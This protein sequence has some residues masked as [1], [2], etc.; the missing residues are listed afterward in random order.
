[1]GDEE[2]LEHLMSLGLISILLMFSAF[3]SRLVRIPP[4][5]VEIVLGMLMASTGWISSSDFV[6]FALSK[7]GFFFLMFLAGME[8]ELKHFYK[9]GRSFIKRVCVYFATTYGLAMFV[10]FYFDYPAFYIIAFPV[11]SVGMIVALLKYYGKKQIWLNTA[12]QIGIVGEFLSIV[13]LV[14]INGFYTLGFTFEL[15]RSLIFFVGFLLFMV[16]LFIIVRSIFWW[17][18]VLR[19]YFIPKQIQMNEDIRFAMMLFFVFVSVVFY[20]KIDVILGAF[21]AG[22]VIANFFQYDK[23]LPKKLHD[24][25]FGFLIPLFF[26]YVGTTLDIKI[27]IEN[28]YLFAN[29]LQIMAI[30]LT[31]H[32]CAHVLAN[33]RFF[34]NLFTLTLSAFSSSVPLTFLVVIATLGQSIG[35]ISNLEYYV[36]VI[37]AVSEG[38]LF[39]LVIKF[40]NLMRPNLKI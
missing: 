25:G 37:T 34:N 18:P 21:F 8:V 31:L 38:V 35:A 10:V 14:V 36:F 15:Y 17:F 13:S 27:I 22:M 16:C 1:M 11:M 29:A 26:I 32:F 5:V 19:L 12:L 3:L 23:N 20:L 33:R 39:V 2:V 24:V 40:L 4:S 6:F 30:M 7:M 9:L 28:Q